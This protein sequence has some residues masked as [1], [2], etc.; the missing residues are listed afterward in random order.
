MA[1]SRLLVGGCCC[2][3][4]NLSQN[5]HR[6]KRNRKEGT[7]SSSV[8]YTLILCGSEVN[9]SP[10]ALRSVSLRRATL[11]WPRSLVNPV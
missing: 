7:L 8:V 3:A 11:P 6:K 1:P 2:A 5:N 4:I 10:R 9:C